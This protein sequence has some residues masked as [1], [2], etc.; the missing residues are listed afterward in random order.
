[1]MSKLYFICDKQTGPFASFWKAN[2][3]GRTIDFRSAGVFDESDL[4]R[5]AGNPDLLFVPTNQI[6]S[7]K[8]AILVVENA[9]I[10]EKAV[11]L[12]VTKNEILHAHRNT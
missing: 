3:H 6:S 8:H 5:F 1:M 12:E 4:A 2:G 9:T 7:E 11:D 10:K